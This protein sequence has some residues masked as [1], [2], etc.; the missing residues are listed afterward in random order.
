MMM[1]MIK[2]NDDENDSYVILIIIQV[3]FETHGFERSCLNLNIF[4]WCKKCY[5][6]EPSKF[7]AQKLIEIII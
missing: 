2:K 6:V 5:E 7:E 4:D 3:N 1:M